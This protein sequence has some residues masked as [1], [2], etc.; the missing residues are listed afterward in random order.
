MTE[1]WHIAL[2][3]P[4][5][6][7]MAAHVLRARGYDVYYPA[8]PKKTEPYYGVTRILMKPMFPGY[9]FVNESLKGWDLLR[10]TPGVR[11]TKPFLIVNGRIAILPEGEIERIAET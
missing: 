5:S 7:R 10:T 2:I 3:E 1:R 11:T 8:F 6:E 4:Q 9:M